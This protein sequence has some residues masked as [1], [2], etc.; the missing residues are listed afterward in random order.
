MFTAA[1]DQLISSYVPPDILS[2]IIGDV[3]SAASGA[4]VSYSDPTSLAY[5]A[6]LATSIPSWFTSAIPTQY[7]VQFASLEADISSLRNLVSQAPGATPVVVPVTSTDS[8]GHTIITSV[9][10]TVVAVTTTASG[11]TTT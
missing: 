10:S 9:T 7:S 3:Q 1:A 6:L 8:N 11:E 2:S 4:S 5:S